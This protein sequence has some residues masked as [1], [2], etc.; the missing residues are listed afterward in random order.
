MRILWINPLGTDAF[1]ADIRKVLDLAKR[2]DTLVDVVSLP[3][4]RPKHLEY[5]AY[6]GLGAGYLSREAP[7]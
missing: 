4:D 3:S 5:H 7:C 6:E 1:D 2:A